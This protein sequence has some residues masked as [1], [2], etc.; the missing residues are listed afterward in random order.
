MKLAVL[1]ASFVCS[2]ALALPLP[3]RVSLN[4][5]G[6]I[7]HGPRTL[8][9]VALTFDADM[10]PGMERELRLGKVRS[11]DN[12]AVV[13]ALEQAQAPATFFLTGMWSQVYP[14]SALALARSP[15]FEV[16]DHSYD[17]PGFSQPCYGLPPIALPGKLPD[18]LRAQRAIQAATGTTPTLFRFPGGCAAESDV[19]TVQAAGLKVVHWDVIGGD[20][21]QPDP[22]VITRTVLS[23]VQN[24]SIVVLHVS[25]G[26]APATGAALPGIIA[27]LRARGYRLVTVQTLLAGAAPVMGRRVPLRGRPLP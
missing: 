25:G 23:R 14:A 6:I 11:F 4:A 7:T 12:E 13:Q 2:V 27:G 17:H 3:V 20:V 15:L 18:I 26:H 8:R 16:E 24:G 5:P 19:K 10:T 1:M 21:N 22:A 9:E